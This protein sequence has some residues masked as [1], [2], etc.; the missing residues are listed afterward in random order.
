VSTS[1]RFLTSSR[2]LQSSL[3]ILA[4]IAQNTDVPAWTATRF[5]PLAYRRFGAA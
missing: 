2:S 4:D 1:T 5:K 3:A